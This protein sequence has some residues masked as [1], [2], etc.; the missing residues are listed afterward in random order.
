MSRKR[1]LVRGVALGYGAV[2]TQIFYSIASIPLTLSYLSSVEFG[3]WSLITTLVAYL[4]VIE[5]GM[6][7]AFQRHLFDCRDEK[8]DGRYGRLFCA[9]LIALGL[10]AIFILVLGIALTWLSASFYHIPAALRQSFLWVMIGQVVLASA[11][12]A[13][14]MLGAPLYIH[15]RQDLAQLSQIVL[16]AILYAVLYF[17]LHAGWGIYAMLANAA[18]GFVW[19]VL[20][21]IVACIRLR[22]YPPKGTWARPHAEELTSVLRYSRDLFI[23]QVGSQLAKNMPMLLLPRLLGL[24]AAAIWTVCTRSFTI[25]KQ[26]VSKPFDYSVPILCEIFVKGEQQRMAKRWMQI[27][28]LVLALSICAFAVGAA[29]NRQFLH[30]WVGKTMAWPA[31]NDWFMALYFFVSIAASSAFGVVGFHKHFGVTRYVPLLEAGLVAVNALWMTRLWG[32]PGLLGA[33]TLAQV[34]A[35]LWF[36]IRHLALISETPTSKLFK[37]AFWRPLR[38]LPFAAVLA[39]AC[40]LLDR[41]LPGY[42][43]LLVAAAVGTTVTGLLALFFGVS[44]E[45]RAEALKMLGRPIAR[46][47]PRR[48]PPPVQVS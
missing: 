30:L 2:V 19:G 27:T 16:Y 1:L 34:G 37:E 38:I 18:A 31:I 7:N 43:G 20:F 24:D 13:T 14:R 48:P 44:V 32:I 25:L 21:N 42:A 6:T 17:G 40:S 47:W 41:F 4:C 28:E 22:L 35:S 5:F 8:H 26:V 11:S 46:F 12:M 23:V 39:W 36:G 45:V 33:A 9:S 29:N 15:Q 3:M 10:V